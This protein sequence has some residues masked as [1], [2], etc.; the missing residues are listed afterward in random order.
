M[1]II[2]KKFQKKLLTKFY[3]YDIYMCRCF[4]RKKEMNEN[5]MGKGDKNEDEE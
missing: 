4:E 1:Q 2:I 5:L 3:V